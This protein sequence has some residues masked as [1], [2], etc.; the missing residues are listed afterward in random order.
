MDEKQR[1]QAYRF[2]AYSAVTFS[3]VAVF[4]FNRT[5]EYKMESG[6][7]EKCAFAHHHCNGGATTSSRL[8]LCCLFGCHLL[9]CRRLLPL[10][11]PSNGLQL[12]PRN[13]DPNQ[14]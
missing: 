9:G 14:P 10:H 3:T 6:E 13:Q 5:E 2:V 4:S 11:Y 7:Q 1:L 8:P 12:R